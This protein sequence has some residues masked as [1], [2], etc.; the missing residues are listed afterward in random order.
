MNK[1][2]KNATIWFVVMLLQY[3]PMDTYVALIIKNNAK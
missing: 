3:N 2:S 1:A